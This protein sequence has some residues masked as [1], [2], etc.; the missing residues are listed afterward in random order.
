MFQNTNF[1]GLDYE[2]VS[3]FIHLENL[4]IPREHKFAFLL[5]SQLRS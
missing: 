2:F 4:K 1:R 3:D 5:W